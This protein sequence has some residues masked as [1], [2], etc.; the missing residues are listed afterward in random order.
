MGRNQFRLRKVSKEFCC[1]T[2]Q[3]YGA[4][5]T[6]RKKRALDND[7]GV[8]NSCYRRVLVLEIV[9]SIIKIVNKWARMVLPRNNV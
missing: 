4:L 9:T 7:S 8:V 1:K 6:S 3:A 5:Y 2:N